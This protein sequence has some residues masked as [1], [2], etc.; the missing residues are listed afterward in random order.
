MHPHALR[1]GPGLTSLAALSAAALLGLC[2]TS[3]GQ[4]YR[5]EPGTLLDRNQR[6]GGSGVNAPTVDIRERIWM[7]NQVITG[8]AP[9]GRSFRGYVGYTAPSEFRASAGSNQYYDFRR[10]SAS[11][12]QVQSG[13]RASDA[14]RYQFAITTGQSVP[15]YL[16]AAFITPR[17]ANAASAATAT[18][19][20]AALRSTADYVSARA[21]RPTVVGSRTDKEGREWSA[22]AS[23]LTGVSWL[24]LD[25]GSPTQAA[26]NQP[27]DEPR[28]DFAVPGAEEKRQ[29]ELERMARFTMTP[30]GLESLSP[31]M[32][33]REQQRQDRLA[34]RPG[35]LEVTRDQEQRSATRVV[36]H[37]R[38]IASVR[39][40]YAAA[41]PGAE[42]TT[43]PLASADR[44]R[45][46]MEEELD[47]LSRVMRGLPPVDPKKATDGDRPTEPEETTKPQPAAETA[48]NSDDKDR[49]R[50]LPP[51]IVAALR[52]AGVKS[53]DSFVPPAGSTD[54]E[55]YRVQMQNGQRA[56]EDQRYFDAEDRFT[57]AI[58][59]MPNDPLAKIARVHAQLGAAL[60]L[61]ASSNL[62][63]VMKSNPE[64][65]GAKFDARLLPSPERLRELAEMLR[66][67]IR[68]G[69]GLAVSSD[70]GL[71][72]AYVG[73][74]SGDRAAIEDGL[75]VFSANIDPGNEP[76]KLL[77][78]LLRGVWLAEEPR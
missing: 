76:D 20:S 60:F 54:P 8:G 27:P 74:V 62:R 58:A 18:G 32:R 25:T 29:Q 19:T 40:A 24:R 15:S 50:P 45:S 30:T 3:M 68:K 35:N 39:E 48:R 61:S 77:A 59:A 37:D 1:Q 7:N 36:E 72:L 17:D 26:P 13:V 10:D 23:P 31:L 21:L 71:L 34:L 65:A 43:G 6:V 33:L 73:R 51:E 2:G 53:I 69:G 5:G 49:K 42:P 78:D 22:T 52:A 70:A 38:F 56:L 41:K 16:S 64:I 9:A 57:R 14:L 55:W 44:P 66:D 47:R 75:R 63:G 46:A 4:Q 28:S 11:S 67:T 12:G